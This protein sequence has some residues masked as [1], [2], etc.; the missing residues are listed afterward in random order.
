MWEVPARDE[1]AENGEWVG[2]PGHEL[3][4]ALS[5]SLGGLPFIA[6]D[7]GALTR[8]VE[9]LRDSFGIP[10]MK[11]LQYAFGGDPN[12][13][14]LP[15]N[16]VPNCVAYTGTHDNDTSVG[17]YKS[18]AKHERSLCRK[19]VNS[20]GREVHWDMIRVILASVARTAILPMQDILGLGSKARMNTP[21]TGDSNWQWRLKDGEASDVVMEKLREMTRIY[22]RENQRR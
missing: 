18:A 9:E 17:W 14:Y 11:I 13:G 20:S 15:H 5:N 21:A 1:T 7:L 19:Y 6:E 12:D 22:G 8:E 16:Y 4:S 2:V 3:F 10:G